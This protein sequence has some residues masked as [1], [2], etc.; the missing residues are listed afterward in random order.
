MIKEKKLI[1]FNQIDIHSSKEYHSDNIVILISRDGK[2]NLEVQN[3]I[4]KF[5]EN[6]VVILGSNLLYK[7]KCNSMAKSVESLEINHDYLTS[8]SLSDFFGSNLKIRELLFILAYD[9]Q[10]PSYQESFVPKDNEF[11]FILDLLKTGIRKHDFWT[12][13]MIRHYIQLI[14]IITAKYANSIKSSGH[15]SGELN[16]ELLCTYIENNYQHI[17]LTKMAEETGYSPNYVNNVLKR[18]TGYTFS[19][20]VAITRI[21]KACSLIKKSNEAPFYEIARA[22]GFRNMNSFYSN[23]FKITGEKPL[24]WKKYNL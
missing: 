23:F 5:S 9:S 24:D 16:L 6:N 14:L 2:G 4:I 7:F 15:K 20:L 21:N 13:K 8:E 18:K 22:V 19:N 10:V 1:N 3:K 17:S 12:T 11:F